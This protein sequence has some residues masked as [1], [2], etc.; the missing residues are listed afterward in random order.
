[1][2][3]EASAKQGRPSV[4]GISTELFCINDGIRFRNFGLAPPKKPVP[5]HYVYLIE[6]DATPGQRYL[7][8]TEDLRKRLADHNAGKNPSTAPDRPWRLRTYLSFS[9]KAQA[10]TFE[11]Y[12]K[13]GSGHAFAKKRL[14]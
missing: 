8:Y 7:G 1:M 10:L 9:N 13:S 2:P 11:T 5:M 3:C 6:S 14:W 12:L 4:M